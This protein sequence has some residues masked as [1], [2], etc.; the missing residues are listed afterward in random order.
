MNLL[1]AVSLSLGVYDKI[2]LNEGEFIKMKSAYLLKNSGSS[3]S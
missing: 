1:D 2:T 3:D